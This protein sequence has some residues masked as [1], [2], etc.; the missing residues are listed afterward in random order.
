MSSDADPA[1][2]TPDLPWP[3]EELVS[4]VAGGVDREAF[5]K[6]GQRSVR[7]IEA[8]LASIERDL[9]SYERILDFGCGCGRIMIWLEEL[10][11]KAELHGVD[12]DERAIEW[13]RAHLPYAT[14]AVNDPLPPLDYPD[15]FFDLVYNHSVFTHIDEHYQDQW[16]AELRR[17]TRP[18]GHLVLSVH[19]E[20][21]TRQFAANAARVGSDPSWILDV[22]RREG[23]CFIHEDTWIGGPFPDFYHSTFHAPWYVFEHWGRF[24]EVRSYIAKGS[25]NFQDFV[26]LERGL[27]E[28]PPA[29]PPSLRPTPRA[30]PAGQPPSEL[31]SASRVAALLREGPAVTSQSRYGPLSRVGRRAVLRVLRHYSEYQRDVAS[32]LLATVREAHEE[33]SSQIRERTTWEGASLRELHVRMSEAVRRQGERVNRLEAELLQALRAGEAPKGSGPSPGD[34]Q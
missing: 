11:R 22:L 8:A 33:A 34:G 27:A 10:G 21:A 23:I 6:S 13:C 9:G 7:D 12:I 16:L 32:L 14:F 3:G 17:V 18:G 26:V 1:T 15:G 19:G 24:F 31:P 28:Q 20:E 5:Y 30:A 25:L 4:R 29:P 2:L